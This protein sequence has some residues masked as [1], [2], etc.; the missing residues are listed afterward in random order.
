MPRYFNLLYSKPAKMR[1]KVEMAK[2]AL[3]N[4]N[5][6][7]RRC[8]VNRFERAGLCLV[9][10][11]AIVNLVAP[12]FGEEA[13]L[14]GHHG[15]GTVFF[16]G[17]NLKCVFCQNHE[18][19]HT[20]AGYPL[21]EKELAEWMLKLQ[22]EG[23][24]HN[25]NFVTPEHVVPQVVLAIAAAAEMGLRIPIVYNTSA[26]DCLESLLLLDGLIDI[27]MPDFK[28]WSEPAS[29]RYLKARDYASHAQAAILEMNRQ[30]GFLRFHPTSGLAMEGLL[31]RHLVMPGLENEGA[32]IMQW[33]A[34]N[35]GKD[36]YV[37]IMEQ[38]RPD[39][40]VG[41]MENRQRLQKDKP[42]QER[43]RYTEINRPVTTEEVTKVREAAERAGLYRFEGEMDYTVF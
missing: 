22:D 17:C 29:L 18:L 38:Y 19:S 33:L 40:F 9:K 13:C 4:C 41:K 24:C 7:P 15:S 11:K 16:S 3:Q 32:L 12:H 25:I 37:H 34:K 6:C 39:A 30:V 8:G 21:S 42:P 31:V 14:Q 35:I 43:A 2:R 1:E 20:L 23:G 36:C 27:Y 28:L 5:L 26:Y 10:D